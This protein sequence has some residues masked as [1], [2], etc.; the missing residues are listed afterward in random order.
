MNAPAVVHVLGFEGLYSVS[1]EGEIKSLA[2]VVFGKKKQTVGAR[3]VGQ[4]DNGAGYKT[5]RLWR[6]GKQTMK[7]VHRVVLE[8]FVGVG[9]DMDACHNDG[10]RANNALSNLRWDTRSSNHVDKLAHGTM[11]NGEKARVARLTEKEVKEIRARLSLGED[12][13][14]L[15]I[16]YGVKQPTISDIKSRRTWHHI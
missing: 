9:G 16:Y 3:V 1:S 15:A 2:R 13:S 10:D 5:V 12:Q 7:Y 4:F 8:A 11:A 14:S 6:D